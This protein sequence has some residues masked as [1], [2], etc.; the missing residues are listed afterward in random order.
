MW[1]NCSCCFKHT[2]RML[3]LILSIS[4]ITTTQAGTFMDH[5]KDPEDG[6]FD[7]SE[8]LIKHKGFLPIPI[9]IS[10]PAVD[11]GLGAGLAFFHKDDEQ[12]TQSEP[13]RNSPPDL[14]FLVGAGTGN[15]SWLA[16]GG[17]WASWK[18]DTVRYLGFASR[19]SINLRFYGSGETPV[20]DNGVDYNMDGWFLLQRL[21]YRIKNSN[22]F[23]GAELTYFDSENEFQIPVAGIEPW[24]FDVRDAGLGISVTYEDLNNLLSPMDGLEVKFKTKRHYASAF[25]TTHEYQITSLGVNK[26]WDLNRTF[27]LGWRLDSNFSS[28]DVPFYALPFIKQR[29]I[30]IMRYQGENVVATEIEGRWKTTPRWILLGFTGVGKAADK[31]NELDTSPSRWAYGGGFRYLVARR[32]GLQVGLDIAKGPEESSFYIIFGNAWGM[33]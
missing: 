15:D 7:M 14:S 12:S 16:G 33:N 3:V 28:G 23:I 10:E 5:F 22:F 18:N 19:Q 24:Q 26:Y 8:W 31:F 1:V 25:D 32:L 11:N 17:H 29:G 13:V 27:A 20:L 21:A 2:V 6:M 9:I 30:P 4:I